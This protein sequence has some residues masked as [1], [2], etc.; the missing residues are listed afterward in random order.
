MEGLAKDDF[1]DDKR[2]QQAV[3]MSLIIGK[4]ATKVMDGY[5]EFTKAHANV[6][7][8]NMRN[9]RNRMAHGYFDI[10][11]NVV[12][13]MAQEWL[14]ALLKQLP[15]SASECRLGWNHD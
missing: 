10:N 12:W 5:A 3:I 8:R 15:A 11:L 9:M 14:P 7:W 2:T 4:A 13:E 1:L 6:P